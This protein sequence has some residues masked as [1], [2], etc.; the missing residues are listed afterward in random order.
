MKNEFLLWNCCVD[1]SCS[2]GWCWVVTSPELWNSSHGELS[3]ARV[4]VF[5][6]VGV[7][8]S[9]FF[10]EDVLGCVKILR[11]NASVGPQNSKQCL[12]ISVVY[13][14]SLLHK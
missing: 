10:R 5:S 14:C 11:Q 4:G 9:C 1:H 12:R 6:M 3:S 2:E 13:S 8:N 7:E